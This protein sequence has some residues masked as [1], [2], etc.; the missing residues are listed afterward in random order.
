MNRTK[1]IHRLKKIK[2]YYKNQKKNTNIGLIETDNLKREFPVEVIV[3]ALENRYI[4]NYELVKEFWE[5]IT[6]EN[7]DLSNINRFWP[8]IER[9]ILRQHP[10]LTKFNFIRTN[11]HID[12]NEIYSFINWYKNKYG[13]TLEIKSIKKGYTKT[14]KMQE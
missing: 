3:A 11:T 4:V 1:I 10:D 8:T 6:N 2:E 13:N 7:V 9:E 14:L 12:D 5:F